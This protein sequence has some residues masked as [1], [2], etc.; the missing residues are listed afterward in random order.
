MTGKSLAKFQGTLD[1]SLQEFQ[2]SGLNNGIYIL[3]ARGEGYNYSQRLVSNA[4]SSEAV[5][6]NKISNFSSLVANKKGSQ[7]SQAIILL[8]YNVGDVLKYTAVSGNNATIMTDVPTV[9]KNVEFQFFECKDADNYYYPIVK[10]GEQYWM[11]ENLKTTK[12]RSGEVIPTT[13]ENINLEVDPVYQFPQNGDENNV[14]ALGRLYT[15][16]AATSDKNVCPTGW[17]LPSEEEFSAFDVL[18]PGEG[19]LYLKEPGVTF[20]NEGNTGKNYSGF[21]ARST[22]VRHQTGRWDDVGART[23][24]FTTGINP[25]N[26]TAHIRR[27]QASTISLGS[28]YSTRVL[29]QAVRCIKDN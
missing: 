5:S 14:N 27:L 4:Y 9:N 17:H 6:I 10:I 18:F 1:V 26:G 3:N 29:G 7:G 8:G 21:A 28:G 19:G 12:F 13:I 15:W 25:D 23:N 11:A 16:A 20:W 22:G 24:Y 2:L